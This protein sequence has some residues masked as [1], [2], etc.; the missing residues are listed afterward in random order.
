MPRRLRRRRPCR[1]RKDRGRQGGGGE[2]GETFAGKKSRSGRNGLG[3]RGRQLFGLTTGLPCLQAIVLWNRGSCY[4]RTVKRETYFLEGIFVHRE[5]LGI[6]YHGISS[7]RSS[8]I[9]LSR[10]RGLVRNLESQKLSF[11]IHY[12]T[13]TSPVSPASHTF[14]RNSILPLNARPFSFSPFLPSILHR[15]QPPPSG[16]LPAPTFPVPLF[17]P[18]FPKCLCSPPAALSFGG[19]A[20]SPPFLSGGGGG[21]RAVRRRRRQRR[22]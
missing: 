20:A 9:K 19:R 1:R 22:S 15:R 3:S 18:P 17:S 10:R 6:Y 7:H 21:G 4:N 13:K 11:L 16:P 14:C 12:H 5:D 8:T 2:G